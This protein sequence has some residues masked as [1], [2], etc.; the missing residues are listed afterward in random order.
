MRKKLIG[1]VMATAVAALTLSGPGITTAQ[2]TTAKPAKITPI[3]WHTCT[4]AT[5]KSAGA[6]CAKV[7]VPLDWSKPQGKQI[8]IAISRV[9]HT[10][11][12]SKYQGVMLVN[13]GGP[14]GSGLIYSVLQG[15]IPDYKGKTV[16]GAY[17]WIGFDPRGVGDSEP[18][19]SC[20]DDYAGYNRPQYDPSAQFPYTTYKVTDPWPARTNA[21]T[22][23]CK[24]KNTSGILK[25]LTTKDV[26]KDMDLIRKRLGA[27]KINYYGFS[28]GTYLGQVY[29]SL[30]PERT[31]RLVF[32]GT[33]D[34]RDVWYDA[35]LN[36]DV[37]FDRNINIWFGW[38]AKYDSTYHLGNTKA[39]V[40]KLF[41]DTR[42]AL[43]ANPVTAPGG[44]HGGS[45]KLGGSE[46]TDAFLYAGYYE[47]T[48]TD[49][50]STF[51]A[52]V[53]DDDVAAFESSYL[54]ASGFGDDNGYAVYTGVQCTDTSWPKSWTTWK[55]DNDAIAKIAP[56]ETWS[57]AWYNEPCRHWPAPSRTPKK[58]NGSKVKSL[59]MLNETLDA[60]TPY[61]GSI[62]VRK[63]FPNASL[64]ATKGGTTHSNSLAGYPCVDDKIARYL[65]NGGVPTRTRGNHA[66][67]YC[68]AIPQPVPES[69]SAKS[70]RKS[71][72]EQLK[73]EQQKLAAPR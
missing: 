16:G 5:L 66:D 13:P 19:V 55:K 21:Y 73:L 31:R 67:A 69:A 35:N 70:Q 48:W 30:F 45:D 72:T 14:G 24:A 4:N 20:N 44:D 29:A 7:Q 36:Q 40:R 11:S 63:L 3:S 33:V 60:A 22:D 12:K 51:S 32:D 71:V 18:K 49:L 23:A 10:V 25:H 41:Y 59:L 9:K 38:L 50:A 47:S 52:Y 61:P 2:A 65:Y 43:Y 56:F 26:A 53:N 42:D 8:K 68:K 64:V 28:Y 6:Q 34:P 46:W 58:I 17:D 27:S 62:Q 54:D 39:E 37:A 15:A 57:N 1:T